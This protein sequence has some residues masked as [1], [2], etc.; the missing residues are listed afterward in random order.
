M[1]ST[2]GKH[3]EGFSMA[4]VA[5]AHILDLWFNLIPC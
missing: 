2:Q 3:G 4:A 1:Q 5:S